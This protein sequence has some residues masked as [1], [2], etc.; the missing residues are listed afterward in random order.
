M[1]ASEKQKE[2]AEDKI[3]MVLKERDQLTAVLNSM[4]KF[5]Y[6][7]FKQFEKQKEVIECYRKTKAIGRCFGSHKRVSA[8]R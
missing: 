6:D 1:E 2:L 4:E 7:L 5:F 8:Q 3:R